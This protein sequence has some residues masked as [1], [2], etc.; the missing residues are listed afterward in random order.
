MGRLSISD[1]KR[2]DVLIKELRL[3]VENMKEDVYMLGPD[4]RNMLTLMGDV[5]LLIEQKL[6]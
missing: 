4:T 1:Q 3:K 5:I 2:L 6:N